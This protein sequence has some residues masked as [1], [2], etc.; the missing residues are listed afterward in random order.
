VRRG[1]DERG[2]DLHVTKVTTAALLLLAIGCSRELRRDGGVDVAVAVERVLGGYEATAETRSLV[3]RVREA[4]WRLDASELHAALP[5]AGAERSVLFEA[6]GEGGVRRI[7]DR[8]AAARSALPD[9]GSEP[10]DGWLLLGAMPLDGG[11]YRLR[12]ATALGTGSA[13]GFATWRGLRDD[14]RDLER[15]AWLGGVRTAFP[16]TTELLLRYVSIETASRPAS[17]G[18]EV[19]V[20]LRADFGR[21]RADYPSLARYAS[22][23]AG[24]VRSS[25]ALQNDAGATLVSWTFRETADAAAISLRSADGRLVPAD[26]SQPDVD[27]LAPQHLLFRHST[28][29]HAYGVTTSIRGIHGTIETD[30]QAASARVESRISGEPDELT[31][32]GALFGV[33]PISAVD[34]FVPGTL[35]GSVRRILSTLLLGRDGLGIEA[36]TVLRAD[37]ARHHVIRSELLSDVPAGRFARLALRLAASMLE[38]SDRESDEMRTLALDAAS[39]LRADLAANQ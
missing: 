19:N 8:A 22:R 1:R 3:H 35:A 14:L 34:F 25:G 7:T 37:S 33:V 32:S 29:M 9:V 6:R 20:V 23:I 4:A 11:D 31:M 28:T 21:L 2:H 12:V 13:D 16:R 10:G 39:R 38:M 15:D 27:P 5:G 18:R 30:P 24:S 36:S 26:D 17:R